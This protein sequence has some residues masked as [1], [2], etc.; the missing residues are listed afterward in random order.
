MEKSYRIRLLTPLFSRGSY[1]D[2]AEMRAPSVRGQ[3]HW[4]FRALGHTLEEE[5][6]L[7]GGVTVKENG[8]RRFED[9][10]SR[11]V[12]RVVQVGE[13]LT[14]R[15]SPKQA[16]LPHKKGGDAAVKACVPAGCE[17]DLFATTRRRP[18]SGKE[19]G[20]LE[21]VIWSW[22]LFGA[23]GNRCNRGGGALQPV[24]EE[25]FQSVDSWKARAAD[26]LDGA[27]FSAALL[28]KSFSSAEA[29]REIATDTIGG[30]KRPPTEAVE[31]RTIRYPL[32][33][34]RDRKHNSSAP[35]RKA[36]PLKLTIKQFED[37]YRLVAVWDRRGGVTGNQDSDL[38][39]AVRQLNQANKTLGR[40]LEPVLPQLIP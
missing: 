2:R 10:A 36:S 40:L 14:D 20:W 21:D 32:G 35:P 34:V 13:I 15:I 5:R 27:K 23:L 7:F 11:V 16:T 19:S 39:A 8:R 6:D 17:F 37:G 1:E 25:C 24:S 30:P 3:L 4:W 22:F 38:E 29:A 33:V 12:I 26:L 31:L 28:E 9:H 18:L